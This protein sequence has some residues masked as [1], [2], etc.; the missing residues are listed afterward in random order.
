MLSHFLV[1]NL[2]PLLMLLIGFTAGCES[3]HTQNVVQPPKNPAVT[4]EPDEPEHDILPPQSEPP[5]ADADQP[6]AN[7]DGSAA[8]EPAENSAA[9]EP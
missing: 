1:R 3:R 2:F 5:L 4:N 6:A 8:K 7:E 9:N